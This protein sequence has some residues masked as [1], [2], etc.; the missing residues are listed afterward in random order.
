[1]L[2]AA[3]GSAVTSAVAAASG[4]PRPPK[5][6]NERLTISTLPGVMA[7]PVLQA[8]ARPC[9]NASIIT[10]DGR[11]RGRAAS[12]RVVGA[13][14]IAT[15]GAGLVDHQ[16]RQGGQSRLE[17]APDPDG[18]LLTGRVLK[19]RNVIETMVI[20]RLNDRFGRGLDFRKISNPA[21]VRIE[22]PADVDRNAEG[23]AVEPGAF[24]A[25]RHV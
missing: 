20:E 19:P 11:R 3:A 10:L 15:A 8:G 6:R 7:P 16:A 23:M 17:P 21:R 2:P 13:P 24:V 14:V 5:A 9:S 12:S 18:Q 4:R 1:M 22:R 25:G